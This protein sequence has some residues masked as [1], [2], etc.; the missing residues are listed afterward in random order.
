MCIKDNFPIRCDSISANHFHRKVI[1]DLKVEI[2]LLNCSSFV[3]CISW[4]FM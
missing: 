1:A 4:A 2:G 3:C